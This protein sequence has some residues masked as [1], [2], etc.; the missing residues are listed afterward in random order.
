MDRNR[1]EELRRKFI[2]DTETGIEKLMK[3]QEVRKNRPHDFDRSVAG[4]AITSATVMCGLAIVLPAAV[5]IM[6]P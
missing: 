6:L 5:V 2:R 1:L 4:F 3:T